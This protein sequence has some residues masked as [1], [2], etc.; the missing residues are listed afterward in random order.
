LNAQPK[1]DIAERDLIAS[2]MP[3]CRATM[4]RRTLGGIALPVQMAYRVQAFREGLKEQGYV[5]GQN[6]AIEYRW[7]EGHLDRLR[8]W[9]PIWFSVR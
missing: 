4:R 9:Q 2:S 5:E 6:V 8:H 7:A 3:V 1:A